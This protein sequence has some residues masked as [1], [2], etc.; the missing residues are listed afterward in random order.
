[1]RG[2]RPDRLGGREADRG[3]AAWRPSSASIRGPGGDHGAASA[4]ATG[5]AARARARARARPHPGARG[6]PRASMTVGGVKIGYVRLAAV[7][8]GRQPRRCARR[9]R[10][11]ASKGAKALVFDLRGD[12][13]GLVTE[14]V[15]VAGVFLPDGSDGRR[16]R[17]AALAAQGLPHRRRRRWPA[18]CPLVVLVDRG[19]ASASEIVA[20]AL[21][22]AKRGHAGGRSAPS[23]RRWCRAPCCCA[24]AARSSS[25]PPAT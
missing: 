17:G 10:A 23:A 19:S 15:G 18:T 14:A 9:S 4:C 16:D 8:P 5:T 20:G 3:H 24:T 22:D 11:C 13:G 6:R 25:R 1:M 12:P 7:H 2:R 21:R